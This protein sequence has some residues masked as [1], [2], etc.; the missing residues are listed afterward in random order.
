MSVRVHELAKEFGIL[1]KELLEHLKTLKVPAKNHM[2]VLDDET[3][4]ILRHEL[5]DRFK[6]TVKSKKSSQAPATSPSVTAP[7]VSAPTITSAR[8][9]PVV[10]S[11]PARKRS[12]PEPAAEVVAA[13]TAVV[14]APEPEAPPPP[15]RLLEV[16]LP[17]TVKDLAAKLGEKT[18][19]VIKR[20]MQTGVL[21]TINQSV[22]ERTVAK[23]A[24]VF[25][26]EL[27][28]VASAEEALRERFQ[29]A[30]S[31]H[32]VHRAPV[33]TLMGHVDHGKTSLLDAVRQTNVTAKEAGG[34]TQHIGAYEVVLPKGRV[35]FLDT[36]GHAAFTAM[37]ARGANV[38]DIVVL[39]VAADDGIM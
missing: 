29:V 25:G 14:A 15:K 30:P 19:E 11:A 16:Q 26:F 33:V 13:A 24:E 17:V 28:K 27:V 39:V 37:R 9:H 23:V 36:P 32:L 3:A 10:K 20:L 12:E 7:A 5:A 18:N 31:A 2:S 1:S 38:T 22:D 21:A 8:A 4:E 35:T 6:K 34:I